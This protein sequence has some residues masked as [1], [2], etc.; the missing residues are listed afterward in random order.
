MRFKKPGVTFALSSLLLL[1]QMVSPEQ[2]KAQ[3]MMEYGGLMAMPKGVP[4]G[5]TVNMLTNPYRSINSKFPG[6]GN[7]SSGGTSDAPAATPGQVGGSNSAMSVDA[8]GTVTL[9]PKKAQ[10]LGAQALKQFEQAKAKMAAKPQ[11]LKGAEAVLREAIN[12]RNSIWGYDD[13]MMPTML[14]LMGEIYAKQKHVSE[15]EACFKNALVYITKKQ[16][17]GSFDRLD[18]LAKLGA[19]YNDNG[20]PKEAV[21][22]FQQVAQIKER[23][24]G[25]LDIATLKAKLHWANVSAAAGKPDAATIYTGLQ[26]NL[27]QSDKDKAGYK[28]VQSEFIKSYGAFLSKAGKSEEANDLEKR[29]S[30]PAPEAK[31]VAVETSVK[32]TD[33]A[34]SATESTSSKSSLGEMTMEQMI[35]AEA[36]LN[37]KKSK[38]KN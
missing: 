3:A 27:D 23:Q 30:S 17:S 22:Y 31:P 24:H 37:K 2:A 29:A 11:D 20:N 15:S 6:N 14:T 34:P 5:N 25:P 36:A 8:L 38:S 1:S 35:N 32:A 19:L 10:I 26:S 33:V 7:S 9:D 4:S 18:T 12:T 16:G 28:E 21:S 13:P